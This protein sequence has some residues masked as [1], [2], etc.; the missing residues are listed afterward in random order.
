V[1]QSRGEPGVRRDT[2]RGL[3][4]FGFEFK[5]AAGHMVS[6]VDGLTDTVSRFH[7]GE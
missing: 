7:V 2:V 3:T 5:D 4:P 1:G 6:A